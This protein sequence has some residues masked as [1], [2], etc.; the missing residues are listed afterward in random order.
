MP[1]QARSASGYRATPKLITKAQAVSAG[2]TAAHDFRDR[3]GSKPGTGIAGDGMGRFVNPASLI[4]L[5]GAGDGLNRA[6]SW[7]RSASMR[8]IGTSRVGSPRSFAGTIVKSSLAIDSPLLIARCSVNSLCH[9]RRKCSP[10]ATLDPKQARSARPPA[11]TADAAQDPSSREEYARR[12]S[13][14]EQDRRRHEITRS[15]A[16]FAHSA[17][18][19]A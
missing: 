1:P 15:V 13:D 2:L 19:A 14:D 8:A 9:N 11:P 5:A 4:S 12:R 16:P 10:G 7:P 17:R 3:F 18:R 6:T